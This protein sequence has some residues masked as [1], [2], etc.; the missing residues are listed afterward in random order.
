MQTCNASVEFAR[1]ISVWG[2]SAGRDRSLGLN[3][4]IGAVLGIVFY[5]GA[6][7]IFALGQ[8]LQWN[9]PLVAALPAI[10]IALCALLMLRRM[11]W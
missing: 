10:I 1:S 9:I 3:I 11:R 5:L 2:V 7:I 6:Q 4:G 8:L